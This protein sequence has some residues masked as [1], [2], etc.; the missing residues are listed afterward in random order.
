[1]IAQRIKSLFYAP[2]TGLVR[3][4]FQP[5]ALNIWFRTRMASLNFPR[6]GANIRTSSVATTPGRMRVSPDLGIG[7]WGDTPEE[8]PEPSVSRTGHISGAPRDTLRALVA[9][10]FRPLPPVSCYGIHGEAGIVTMTGGH[11]LI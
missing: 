2:D 1:M 8:H 5:R 3:M 10:V 6:G 11:A 4:L 7:S 9:P